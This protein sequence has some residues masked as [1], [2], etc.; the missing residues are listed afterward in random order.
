MSA[1]RSVHEKRSFFRVFSR[2]DLFTQVLGQVKECLKLK[3]QE[4]IRVPHVVAWP[5]AFLFYEQDWQRGVLVLKIVIFF[6]VFLPDL[7]F[8]PNFLGRL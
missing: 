1:G 5:I 3:F 2:F 8:F 4:M 7:V 6:F